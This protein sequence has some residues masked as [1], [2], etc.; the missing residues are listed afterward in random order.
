VP[1]VNSLQV[2]AVMADLTTSDVIWLR[3]IVI[4]FGFLRVAF[5]PLTISSKGLLLRKPQGNME[6][7]PVI[8]KNWNYPLN[9][10]Y[11]CYKWY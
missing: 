3:Y 7:H 2:P 1:P 9:F 6:C 4:F 5:E 8:M 11:F 10:T